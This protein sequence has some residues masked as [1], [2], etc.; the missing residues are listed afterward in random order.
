MSAT[1][2]TPPRRI[3]RT[4]VAG[5]VLVAVFVLIVLARV[6][7][8]QEQT[9]LLQQ[10][11]TA[12]GFVTHEP[13]PS[14]QE[15]IAAY[16]QGAPVESNYTAVSLYTSDINGDWLQAHDDLSELQITDLTL[17]ETAFTDAELAR[18]VST[19]PLE[20]VNF[21]A[22]HVGDA[23]IAAL[24]GRPQLRLLQIRQSPLTDEQFSRLPL[25]QL[26]E[27]RIDET[28]ITPVGLQELRRARKLVLL[29]IDG[30]QF[31]A[32]TASLL[33]GLPAFRQIELAGEAV[34]DDHLAMLPAIA[35]LEF[36]TL[37]RTAVT[38]EGLKSLR[39]ALPMCEVSTR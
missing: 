20:F 16:R 22:E 7:R 6:R 3:S 24:A 13:P 2:Q 35:A 38:E 1:P 21:R 32:S 9:D 19:H 37:N 12:G 10:I 18:F 26:E 29:I 8:S 28:G 30:H 34:T 25:E 14:L 27:L 33:A 11:K 39:S 4:L 15:R 5:A 17:A 31:D 36:V 23:T